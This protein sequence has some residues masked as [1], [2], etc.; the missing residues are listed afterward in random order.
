[1]TTVVF[2]RD[3]YTEPLTQ[4]LLFAALWT[5]WPNKRPLAPGLGTAIGFLLG[6]CVMTRIDAVVYLIPLVGWAFLELRR[7][8]SARRWMGPAAIAA[9]LPLTLAFMD[10]TVYS[11]PYSSD[12]AP[13][14]VPLL[15]AFGAVIG[16]GA[17][18]AERPALLAR[19]QGWFHAR[20]KP[21][22]AVTACVVAAVAFLAWVVRPLISTTRAARASSYAINLEVLQRA[23]GVAIDGSRTYAEHSVQWLGWYLGPTVMVL[24]FGGLAY[25]AWRLI[26]G[27]RREL[28]PFMALFTVVT[29]LYAWRP[30][31]DPN[32]VWAMRRFFPV[33]IPGL[34]LLAAI[35]VELI[36]GWLSRLPFSWRDR[37][38]VTV[39]LVI[40]LGGPALIIP[41]RELRPVV[42]ER[43]LVP[44]SAAM[45]V[46]CG[47]LPDH[48]LVYIPQPGLFADRV[49][50]P[51]RSFCDVS[52]AVGDT[53]PADSAVAS[54][55][56]D[57]AQRQGRPFVVLSDNP[58]PFGAPSSTV[59]ESQLAVS[60]EYQRLALTVESVPSDHW[61]EAFE[62]W[63][64]RWS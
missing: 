34:L 11:K 54:T 35:A 45:D 39:A 52:V 29:A 28:A 37:R 41:L 14:V 19:A 32:Q 20:R 12:L 43:E 3:A 40:C 60:V 36:G 62:V 42:F 64:A 61:D 58:E 48:A 31:I 44:L 38:R 1:M 55:L 25:L 56:N 8:R 33:T 21:I 22:A 30:S 9:S 50:Q 26:R 46:V 63:V 51:L 57:T 7:N 59:P 49:A 27:E 13:S 18:W 23:E 24:G 2:A 5:L 53:L 47:E 16:V 17:V 10:A 4:L 15:V 6:V